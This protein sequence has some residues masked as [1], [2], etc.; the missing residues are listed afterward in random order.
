MKKRFIYI[1]AALSLSLSLA[2]CGS[3]ATPASTPAPADT[4]EL[5]TLPQPSLDPVSGS[6]IT[7]PDVIDRN[8][9]KSAEVTNDTAFPLIMADG[10]IVKADLDGDGKAE[11]VSV[12]AY[13]DGRDVW[14]LGSLT[15]NGEDFASE[16]YDLGYA[17]YSP[18]S[19]C[20]A[21]TDIVSGDGLLEI[22]VQDLGPSD[23]YTTTFF[24][25]DGSRL[26]LLG[27]VEGLIYSSYTGLGDV[28]FD[29]SG[30][31]STYMRLG[32]LQT[33]YANVTWSED[34]GALYLED[35]DVYMA[36]A[37]NQAK[38]LVPLTLYA[39]NDLGSA[40]TEI[41][42]GEE[43]TFKGSDNSEW[44]LVSFKGGDMWLHLASSYSV[45][46]GGEQIYSWEA[47]DG[48]SMAD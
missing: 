47:F 22:A 31:I 5:T 46:S 14:L 30:S 17:G 8:L 48:L 37:E 45:E 20:F 21:I 7:L 25:Y 29:G 13:K 1:A 12:S 41:S 2:A 27:T 18:D 32:V 38:T 16:V 3:T 34:G 6:D 19:A 33:W 28:G 24:R 11:E 42:A 43:L 15:I 35:S 44:V 9:P 40:K 36:V 23:D 26:H 39:S 4:P 10:G